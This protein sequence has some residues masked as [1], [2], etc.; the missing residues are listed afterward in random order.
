M[1]FPMA[2]GSSAFEP[3]NF[4]LSS[5][6]RSDTVSRVI[7]GTSIPMVPFPGIGAMMRIPR[8]ARL[9]AMSS[10]RF[11]MRL[12]RTPGAGTISYIVTVG[13]MVALIWLILI[14]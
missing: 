13:P 7:L 10:S 8:A 14:S 5:S 1:V 12:M 6:E 9:N 4:S 3:V 2:N 11:F